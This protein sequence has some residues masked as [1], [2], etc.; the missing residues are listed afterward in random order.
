MEYFITK[1]KLSELEKEYRN[2]EERIRLELSEGTPSLLEGSDL[3][4]DFASYE[5]ELETNRARLEEIDNIL[6]HHVI[7]KKPAEKD[8][9]KVFL[10]AHVVLKNDNHKTEYRIV[11]TIEANPFEG[12]ISD[13]SPAGRAFMGKAVGDTVCVGPTNSVYKILEVNYEEV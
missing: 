12:K 1:Q 7:I 13:A 3:N 2:I 8:R 5:E 11:G 6:K 10:G 4:P 9:N